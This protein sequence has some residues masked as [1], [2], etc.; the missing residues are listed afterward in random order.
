MRGFTRC[1]AALFAAVD[2][3][4][5]LWSTSRPAVP[6]K[7]FNRCVS[8]VANANNLGFDIN[9]GT[10]AAKDVLT[11]G[12]PGNPDLEQAVEEWLLRQPTLTLPGSGGLV[13]PLAYG[14][15]LVGILIVE[16]EHISDGS[17]GAP[18]AAAAGPAASRAAGGVT[19]T[20]A[21]SN[22]V[23]YRR[24]AG[25]TAATGRQF[26]SHAAS[27]GAAGPAGGRGAAWTRSPDGDPFTAEQLR[28]VDR[29]A[30]GLAMACALDQ[31]AAL[32]R[33]G[34]Q[35]DRLRVRGLVEEVC[36]RAHVEG[37]NGVGIMLEHVQRQLGWSPPSMTVPASLY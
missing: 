35:A 28:W 9:A 24:R 4:A 7:P 3:A 16:Q 21:A 34:N 36:R 8:R 2:R 33:A 18:A 11:L 13:L 32:E 37:M 6:V 23:G 27:S 15:F 31:R 5:R 19:S 29:V 30:H 14:R 1:K 20:S 22:H 25:R 26:A 10:D 17:H 12:E